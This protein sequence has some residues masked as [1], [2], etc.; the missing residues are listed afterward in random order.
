MGGADQPQRYGD[1]PAFAEPLCLPGMTPW[2]ET[3]SIEVSGLG[4]VPTCA[5][6]TVHS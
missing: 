4:C 5:G 3:P 6:F 1:E 2:H